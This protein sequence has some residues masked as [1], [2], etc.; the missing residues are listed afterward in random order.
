M[1]L[2]TVGVDRTRWY[3]GLRESAR[4]YRFLWRL[5][6]AMQGVLPRTCLVC[7]QRGL[8][9]FF[10]MPA[11]IDACRPNCKSL[12]RHRL[13]AMVDRQVG[14][15]R[16]GDVLHFAPERALTDYLRKRSSSYVS[17]DLFAEGVDMKQN[18]EALTLRDRSFDLIFCSH[19]LEHVDDK[20]AIGELYRVLR[21]AGTLIA[22]VPICEGWETTYENP[23]ITR[24]EERDIHFGQRDHVRYYGRDFAAR[25]EQAGFV[26]T[27]HTASPED[28]VTYG[29]LRGEEVYVCRKSQ[30]G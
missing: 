25:L 13:F 23:A 14:L 18:I 2:H 1:A 21:P 24:P 29:L 7:G 5:N 26:V 22:M 30:T 27:T 6:Q 28:I 3:T 19:V 10:G 16:G 11:R 12:E 8:F 17:A 4:R 9:R 15:V 20:R